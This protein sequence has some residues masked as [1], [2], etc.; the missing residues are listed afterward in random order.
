MPQTGSD[1]V[2]EGNKTSPLRLYW[3]ANTC[4]YGLESHT[5]A[6]R[7]SIMCQKPQSANKIGRKMKRIRKW[8]K[9]TDQIKT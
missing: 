4:M 3:F 1:E 9:T 2:T 6:A 7:V 5:I 8:Q